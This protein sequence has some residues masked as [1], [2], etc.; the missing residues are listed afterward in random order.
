MLCTSTTSLLYYEI[1]TIPSPIITSLLCCLVY[2]RPTFKTNYNTLVYKWLVTV[3]LLKVVVLLLEK[4]GTP[5]IMKHWT[6]IHEMLHFQTVHA[7]ANDTHRSVT[8][9]QSV[10]GAEWYTGNMWNV[11]SSQLRAGLYHLY[12]NGTKFPWIVSAQYS[13]IIFS[14]MLGLNWHSWPLSTRNPAQLTDVY[15]SVLCTCAF[16]QYKG[17]NGTRGIVGSILI[18]GQVDREHSAG[19]L[20]GAGM[21][22]RLE[23]R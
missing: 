14:W 5:S 13:Q 18:E 9:K 15:R 19:T 8:R 16:I 11:L 17:S 1:Q 22:L 3:I 2:H 6:N 20:G 12:I 10:L 4:H 7:T 23:G 21:L